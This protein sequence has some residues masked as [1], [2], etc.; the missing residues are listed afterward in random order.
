MADSDFM[1]IVEQSVHEL[2]VWVGF[3]TLVG[4]TAKAIM[5]GRDPGGALATMMMGIAGSVIGCG[6]VMFFVEGTRVSPISAVGFC[7]AT[8]GAFLLLFF[9]RLLAGSFFVEAESGD[10]WLH[11]VRRRRRRYTMLRDTKPSPPLWGHKRRGGQSPP[12]D[13]KACRHR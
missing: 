12:C 11:R 2:L 13:L 8:A 5:P 1:I 6:L 4:L 9:Y 10:N 7:A 3:G